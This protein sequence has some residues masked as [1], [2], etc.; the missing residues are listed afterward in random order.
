MPSSENTNLQR[1]R[2]ITDPTDRAAA[3]QTFIV[4]GRE[5]LRAVEHL[6]DESIREARKT[7]AGTI[8]RIAAAVNVKRNI[9]V[10]ALRGWKP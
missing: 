3:C 9:V 4:N 8:D 2:A 7:G 5:T 10:D 1:L 6:R